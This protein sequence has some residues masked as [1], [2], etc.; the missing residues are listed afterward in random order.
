MIAIHL[1]MNSYL[2]GIEYRAEKEVAQGGN[3]LS[4][5]YQMTPLGNIQHII[6]HTLSQLP[7]SSLQ[8]RVITTLP[9]VTGLGTL[10]I[11][12]TTFTK[13]EIFQLPKPLQ[14]LSILSH[15]HL[16]SLL[17]LAT[18]ISGIALITL[19]QLL[20]GTLTLSGLLYLYLDNEGYIPHAISAPMSRYT[21]FLVALCL[22]V[23]EPGL[24]PL[25]QLAS[26]STRIL[27]LLKPH[28]PLSL[29]YPPDACGP[30]TISHELIEY[31]HLNKAQIDLI[32]QTDSAH[33]V[34]NPQPL[35]QMAYTGVDLKQDADIGCLQE[36]FDRIDWEQQKTILA[37]KFQSDDRFIEHHLQ[38]FFQNLKFDDLNKIQQ[39]FDTY[40]ALWK[41]FGGTSEP[42]DS[43]DL[44]T[45][46]QKLDLTL[47]SKVQLKAKIK[48]YAKIWET[49][50]DTSYLEIFKKKFA[51]LMKTL[52][53]KLGHERLGATYKI[54]E[55]LKHL[56][57]I[58][59]QF[60]K[61]IQANDQI[62]IQD[63]LMRLGIEGGDYCLSG[64]E[65][66]C[67]SLKQEAINSGMR[68][69]S[70]EEYLLDLKYQLQLIREGLICPKHKLKHSLPKFLTTY[71]I[72]KQELL[73]DVHFNLSY[74]LG[75]YSGFVPLTSDQ[76]TKIDFFDYLTNWYSRKSRAACLST[77]REQLLTTL[78]KKQAKT[79]E[80]I[81]TLINE[82]KALNHEEQE[83]LLENFSS[84]NQT[85]L[86][87]FEYLMLFQLGIVK[88]RSGSSEE[89]RFKSLTQSLQA[90]AITS[91]T[92]T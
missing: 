34:V 17:L 15:Q 30:H 46:L 49:L 28:I 55:A 54:D 59:P 78:H 37:S 87:S 88:F 20:A 76:V 25:I 91:A 92:P 63:T 41:T 7:T 79:T 36:Q 81:V 21:P 72:K 48:E 66:V 10:W 33:F 68:Q 12:L 26:S 13:A 38:P 52:N 5:M 83:A 53:K 43:T 47:V 3:S 2:H 14:A 8:T 69:G 11:I 56:Y 19:G 90:E 65:E 6:T 77:Y 24:F 60:K 22:F 4:S 57:Y 70:P 50:C 23:T 1:L 9:M 80:Y 44:Q 35:S 84:W 31:R 32:L 82:N 89:T 42:H 73:Q 58:I 40:L 71:L 86:I 27:E 16:G 62:S 51:H 75:F 85:S 29:F 45:C 67:Q 74:K 18:V 39:N 61:Q 64:L